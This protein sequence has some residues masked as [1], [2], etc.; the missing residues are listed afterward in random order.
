MGK[1]ELNKGLFCFLVR[2]LQ[3]ISGTAC[4]LTDHLLYYRHTVS[5]HKYLDTSVFDI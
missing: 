2:Q 5:G 4:L 3:L 1:E